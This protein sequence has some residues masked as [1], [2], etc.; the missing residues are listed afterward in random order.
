MW[1][2]KVVEEVRAVRDAHAA[3]FDYDLDAIYQ[4]LKKQEKKSIRQI[5]NLPPKCV[6][7]EK[8]VDN[9]ISI[10]G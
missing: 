10:K 5:V 7:C 3:R 2:D 1:V 4:D 6:K 8:S 9:A